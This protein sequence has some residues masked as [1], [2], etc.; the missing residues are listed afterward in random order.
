LIFLNLEKFGKINHDKITT[1]LSPSIPLWL[2]PR[3]P[4]KKSFQPRNTQKL[5]QT[6]RP[7]NRPLAK[8]SI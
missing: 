8:N 1:K 6:T 4:T 5:D 7:A 2:A 3:A